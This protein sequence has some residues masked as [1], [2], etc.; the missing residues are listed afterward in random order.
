MSTPRRPFFVTVTACGVFLLGMWNA[1]RALALVRQRRLLIQLD[2]TLH[3]DA[4]LVMAV[5]WTATF[6]TVAAALW[7]RRPIVRLALPVSLFLYALYH[8]LLSLFFVRAPAARL[9]WQADA[10][11]YAA[12]V[13]WAVWVAYRPAHG[14]CW[15]PTAGKPMTSYPLSLFTRIQRGNDGQSKD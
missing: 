11:L 3:P 9:G 2:P 12:A 7:Q 15:R 8:L 5:I 14:N 13:A 10:L 1:W 6:V 4:R